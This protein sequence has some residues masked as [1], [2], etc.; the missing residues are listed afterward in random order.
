MKGV[1]GTGHV[2]LDE[3]GLPGGRNGVLPPLL[4]VT[5]AGPDPLQVWDFSVM[6][7]GAEEASLRGPQRPRPWMVVLTKDTDGETH[8]P[9]RKEQR[10]LTQLP[11]H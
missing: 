8:P 2:G 10:L 11:L 6:L 1:R 7:M 5:Q 9:P 4:A 3:S